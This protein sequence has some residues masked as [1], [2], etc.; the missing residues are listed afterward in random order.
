[1]GS[2]ADDDDRTRML[3]CMA[4]MR[5]A[6]AQAEAERDA[7]VRHVARLERQLAALPALRRALE[8]CAA[9]AREN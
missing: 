2:A 5:R 1:M 3:D 8:Q 4:A 7:L 6:A 9:P